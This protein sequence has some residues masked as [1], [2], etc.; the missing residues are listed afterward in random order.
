MLALI[1]GGAF[2]CYCPDLWS[3]EIDDSV[4]ASQGQLAEL[5][6]ASGSGVVPGWF[7]A[8]MGLGIAAFIWWLVQSDKKRTAKML[9]LVT[10]LGGTFH[11][12]A[13]TAD[14]GLIAGSH[15]ATQGRNRKMFNIVELP[16]KERCVLFDF[17]YWQGPIGTDGITVVMTVVRFQSDKLL[18][19]PPFVL[20]PENLGDK[21]S[22]ALGSNDINFPEYAAFSKKY[23][24]RS[25]DEAAARQFFTPAIIA[26]FEQEPGWFAEVSGD[27][28]FV[29]RESDIP[30]PE[31]IPGFLENR[32]RVLD[33]LV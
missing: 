3:R 1:L 5:I 7:Y 16:P 21:V 8:V 23:L 29:Y 31:E 11:K 4:T 19:V 13:T 32:R 12:E 10:S 20:R 6:V 14:D 22:A 17:Q 27:R 33:V 15:L 30:N 28:L 2:L 24:L 25:Q 9:S 26:F 18:Q